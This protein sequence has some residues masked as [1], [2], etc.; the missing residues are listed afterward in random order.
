MTIADRPRR[1]TGETVN[2]AFARVAA[3]AAAVV[4]AVM[5]VLAALPGT[6]Q[7]VSYSTQEL[8]FVRLLNEYRQ[9][10]GV[11]PLMV[12][13]LCSNAAEKHSS[14]MGTYHFFAHDT[15]ASDFFPVGSNARVRLALSGYGNPLAWGE[16]IAA[17]FTTATAVLNAWKASPDHDPHMIDP[18]YKVVGVGLVYV[19]GSEYGYYWTTDFG[20][21]VDQTAHWVGDPP[22]SSSTTTTTVPPPSTTT[23][24]QPP[25]STTTTT[26]PPA[27]PTFADVP[28]THTFYEAITSLAAAGVVS[29]S[30]DGLFHP[31]AYVTRAQF[32][33]I[34][35]LALDRHTPAIDNATSPTFSDV[36]YMG[37]AYPFDY[38]EEAAGLGIVYG[39]VN[40]TFG[41]QLNVTR[42]QLAV[43]LVRAGGENLRA[44]PPEYQLPFADVPAYG[45]EAVLIAVFNGLVSGKTPTIFDP[46]VQATRGHVAKMVYGLRQV[47]ED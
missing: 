24:T 17:G 10:M 11:P 6:A 40:G 12:S 25:P 32:A 39:F 47:L 9:S 33:K 3:V 5:L 30:G 8:E 18:V 23:T 22:P 27:G 43:M 34:I 42:L 41:P 4:I 14:D 15:V 44:P 46:Y 38:V 13:D 45:R 16:N 1:S 37:A 2:R 31:D 28:P 7:A 29:G 20:A 21:F 35:V 26:E 19:P 36:P